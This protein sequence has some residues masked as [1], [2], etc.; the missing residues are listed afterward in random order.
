MRKF[1]SAE[2]VMAD[3]PI[4]MYHNQKDTKIKVHCTRPSDMN[5]YNLTY[6]SWCHGDNMFHKFIFLVYEIDILYYQ[7]AISS[8]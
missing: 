4:L 5:K 1:R 8:V 7:F 6:R 3:K 2:G